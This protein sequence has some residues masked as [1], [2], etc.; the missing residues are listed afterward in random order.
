MNTF[1]DAIIFVMLTVQTSLRC[2]GYKHRIKNLLPKPIYLQRFLNQNSIDPMRTLDDFALHENTIFKYLQM[3][4]ESIKD[5]NNNRRPRQVY[6][7]H[8]STVLPEKSPQP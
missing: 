3:D 1:I 4:E 8:Y 6:K 5:N 2:N 7:A